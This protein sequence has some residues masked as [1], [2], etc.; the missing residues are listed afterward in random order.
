MVILMGLVGMAGDVHSSAFPRGQILLQDSYSLRFWKF[1]DGL[2]VRAASEKL[3]HLVG[4]KIIAMNDV[5]IDEAWELLI[6]KFPSENEWMST[7]M[8]QLFIQFPSLLHVL[9]L[10][11]SETGGSWTF[12]MPDGKPKTV[13]LEAEEKG[14]QLSTW[15]VDAIFERFEKLP[16]WKPL[17][18][19]TSQMNI[20]RPFLAPCRKRQ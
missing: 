13:Y 15:E 14:G 10:N 4:A 16:H 3:K 9:G 11:E 17:I 20:S 2:Y 6:N 5:P 19:R 18:D 1:S 8:I 12:L 7:Y